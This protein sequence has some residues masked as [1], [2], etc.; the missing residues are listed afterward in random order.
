GDVGRPED[1]LAGGDPTLV[2]AD[3]DETTALDD[4]EVRRVRVVVEGDPA[5]PL[6]GQL[7]DQ[8]AGIRVDD[9]AF[10]VDRTGR[11]LGPP[12]PGA[13][14]ADVDP[15]HGRPPARASGVGAGASASTG[16]WPRAGSPSSGPG[17]AAG[18]AGARTPRRAADSAG[19]GPR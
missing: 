3:L 8:A 11:P 5:A 18:P 14:P 4:A 6:E 9:L 19:S 15:R 12:M 7:R 16:W 17:S 1:R 10:H 13:E 2:L